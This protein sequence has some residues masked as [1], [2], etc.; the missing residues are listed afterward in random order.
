MRW[1]A[2]QEGKVYVKQNLN[3]DQLTVKD[4]QEMIANGDKHIADRIMRFGEG[5]RG[6]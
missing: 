5:L 3:D 6:S 2:L 4:I 1:R